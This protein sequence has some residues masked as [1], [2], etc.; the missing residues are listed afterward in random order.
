MGLI[1]DPGDKVSGGRM[2]EGR[3]DSLPSLPSVVVV[4]Q[5]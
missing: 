4:S 3:L 2:Q 1:V 5:S